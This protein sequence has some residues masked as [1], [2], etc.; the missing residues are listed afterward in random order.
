MSLT[1]LTIHPTLQT[2]PILITAIVPFFNEEK[3]VAKVV[4]QLLKHPLLDEIIC[5]NDGSTDGSISKLKQFGKLI[6]IIEFKRNRGKGYAM[7]QGILAAKGDIV[8][9][10]DSDL[11]NLSQNHI[12]TL[13]NPIVKG[14]ARAVLGYPTGSAFS[15]FFK[16]VTGER[17][18]YRADLL[19]H[20]DKLAVT[21][22]FSAEYHLN[23]LFTPKELKRVPLKKLMHLYKHEK[24]KPRQAVKEVVKD[25]VTITQHIG[26]AEGLMTRDIQTIIA[27]TKKISNLQNLRELPDTINDISNKQVKK[28]LQKIIVYFFE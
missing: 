17:A 20:L 15:P 7:A 21:T 4:K 5:V 22:R 12:N 9:F 1:A 2:Q 28:Y 18:Y 26:R 13:L 10:F 8:A 11:N 19:D 27:F 24:Y 3:N 6:R 25:I 23:S 14:K 16:D